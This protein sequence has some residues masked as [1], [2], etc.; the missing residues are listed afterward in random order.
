MTTLKEVKNNPFVQEFIYQTEVALK[1]LEYTEHGFRHAELVSERAKKIAQEIGL[2]KKN[3]E[4]AAIAGFCHDM[5]NF[6][7]RTQHHYWGA[8]LF[9]QIFKNKFSPRDLSLIMQA[10]ANHDKEE[11]KLSNPISPVVVL[12]DKSDVHRSR[13]ITKSINK[14]KTDI[15]DRVNYATTKSIIKVNKNK[16]NITLNLKIDTNFVPIIEYFEIFTGRM[17]YCRKAAEYLGYKFALVINNFKL[18]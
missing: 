5:G 6:L 13:V 3:Q 8:L 1:A 15:H 9:S 16:K 4:L 10:I 18:L 12:A 17:I 2:S 11:M 7:G 14:I